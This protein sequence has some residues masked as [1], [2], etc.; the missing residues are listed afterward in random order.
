MTGER[1]LLG[2]TWPG[3]TFE[4]LTSVSTRS[5]LARLASSNAIEEDLVESLSKK[6][7]RWF[8]GAYR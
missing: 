4:I 6:T 7:T 8:D 3:L 2:G 5:Y 1:S